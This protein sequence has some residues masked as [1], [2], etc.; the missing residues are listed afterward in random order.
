MAEGSVT[1]LDLPPLRG[2]PFDLRPIESSRAEH[3]VGRDPLLS[4]LRGYLILHTPRMVL[5]VGQ[6]GS[7]RTSFINTLASQTSRRSYIGQFWPEAEDP[8][9]GIIHEISVHI[10]GFEVAASMQLVSDR[11]VETLDKETGVLP[12]IALDYP[13][14]IDLNSTLARLA[15]LL[16]RLRALVVV[17]ITPSQL[18]SLNDDVLDL[19]DE[20]Q[21]LSNLNEKQIQSLSNHRISKFANQKWIIKPNL[22]KAIHE[23]TDGNPRRVVRLLRDLVEERRDPMAGGTLERLVTWRHAQPE[24]REPLSESEPETEFKAE[25]EAIPPSIVETEAEADTEDE[26]LNEDLNEDLDEDP[27]DLWDDADE[28]ISEA[29]DEAAAIPEEAAD[30]DWNKGFGSPEKIWGEEEESAPASEVEPT[31]VPEAEPEPEREP[32]AAA[33]PER[34]VEVMQAHSAE[35]PA[36]STSDEGETYERTETDQAFLYMEGGTEPTGRPNLSGGNFG[37]L[38]KRTMRT[39]DRMPT[40][41]DETPVTIAQ[42]HPSQMPRAQKP[43]VRSMPPDSVIEEES[44]ARIDRS[45]Q[46]IED[47]HVYH[48]DHALWVVEP[49]SETSLPDE[50]AYTP[51]SVASI[52]L[53]GEAIDTEWFVAEKPESQIESEPE[54]EVPFQSEVQEM[55]P[56]TLVPEMPTI[57]PTVP[58]VQTVPTIPTIPT[59]PTGLTTSADAPAMD[60]PP[61]IP[62]SFGPVWEDDEPFD[63]MCLH[64]LTEAERM[65][66]TAAA[67]REVSPSDQELQARLEVGRSRLSQIYNG[68]RRKGLLSVRKQGRTRFFK[69]S[70]ATSQHFSGAPKGVA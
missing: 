4:K 63:A 45:I 30:R 7:G 36:E 14:H 24:D 47:E 29:E 25:P 31:L 28:L 21:R 13:S 18:S 2:N 35:E 39:S 69:L 22:L 17:A 65:I 23:N 55:T 44:Q 8:T 19:F 66:L 60:A 52:S 46:P 61:V 57:S 62:T 51:P 40:A 50:S 54:T 32:E 9:Q 58:T 20:P 16:Q 48:T 41:L 68:M 15:P 49:G 11:L 1:I 64:T 34:E 43:A 67:S 56:P 10:A 5:L 37:S 70:T 42:S 53:G 38:L 27:D 6:R 33:E 26:D 59:I 3:L 12:L